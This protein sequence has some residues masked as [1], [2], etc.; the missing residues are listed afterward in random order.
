MPHDALLSTQQ[1]APTGSERTNIPSSWQNGE[2]LGWIQR[3]ATA[4]LAR[5][6]ALKVFC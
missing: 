1:A 3:A 4:I 6:R 5:A 2:G